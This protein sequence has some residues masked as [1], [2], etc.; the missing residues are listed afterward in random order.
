MALFVWMHQLSQRLLVS[1]VGPPN[2]KRL[3]LL[4]VNPSAT[5]TAIAERCCDLISSERGWSIDESSNEPLNFN[6]KPYKSIPSTLD[7]NAREEQVRLNKI[8]NGLKFDETMHGFLQA[9]QEICDFEAAAEMAESVSSYARLS[10]VINLHRSVQTAYNGAVTGILSYSALSNEP[11]LITRGTVDFFTIDPDVSDALN[12][13]YNLN[14]MSTDGKMYIFRGHKVVDSSIAFSVP[15]TWR[16]TTTL[17][18]TISQPDGTQ[19][20]KGILK[21]SPK[22]LFF[23]LLSLRCNPDTKY[24]QQLCT[25][26]RFLGSF[27]RKVVPYTLSPLRALRYSDIECF[28][29]NFADRM[30]PIETWVESTDGV[31]IRIKKWEPTT[32]H[33]STKM[34]IV[35]I[36]GASVDDQIFSLATIPTNTID[37]LTSLGHR[38]YVPILRFGICDEAKKGWT[39]FDA[40]LDVKAALQYIREKEGN[41]PVYAIAHCLGSIAL[42]T[43]LL[44][45]DVE[46]NWLSGLACSQ[47]FT[48]L[49]YSKDNDFK[50][51]HQS[52]IKVYKVRADLTKMLI[53]ANCC[54]S[55]AYWRMVFLSF[56]LSSPMDSSLAGS[57]PT[58]VPYRK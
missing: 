33:T 44:H 35:L 11:L 5:I 7:L 47:V 49:V 3:I 58:P 4:G 19:V 42:A 48:D 43:A 55:D 40:R 26:L 10:M 57:N 17:L 25:K 18:T 21:L 29:A 22:D 41:R 56:I 52:L 38:C 27:A 14:L 9:T 24:M 30:E 45:G 54:G 31:R 50:A 23:Q 8:L 28:N 13:V 34:P 16:A 2:I 12:L 20:A 51:R 15:R 46:A 36:P 37:Y 6:A 1:L 39:V 53:V 32:R